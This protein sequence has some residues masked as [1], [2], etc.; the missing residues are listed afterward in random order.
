MGRMG[1]ESLVTLGTVLFGPFFAS[2]GVVISEGIGHRTLSLG[3]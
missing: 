3:E 1:S 2:S